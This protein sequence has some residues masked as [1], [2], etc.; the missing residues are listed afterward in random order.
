MGEVPAQEALLYGTR[1]DVP[2]NRLLGDGRT[3]AAGQ[4]SGDVAHRA[5]LHQLAH[6]CRITF[7]AQHAHQLY[8]FDRVATQGEEVVEHAHGFLQ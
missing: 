1:L 8:Q 4:H 3:T 6:L 5:A 7:V 2:R